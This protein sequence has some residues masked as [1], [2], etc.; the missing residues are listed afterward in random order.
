VINYFPTISTDNNQKTY[1]LLLSVEL[2]S[3]NLWTPTYS[4][5]QQEIF[6]IITKFHEDDKWNFKQISD[7]LNDNDY[8]TTRGCKFKHTHAWSIYQKKNRSIQRF[9]REFEDKITDMKIHVID[10][11]SEFSSLT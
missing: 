3:A 8:K 2:K 7:W 10:N 6:D 9:S 5:Y 4:S 11:V 1:S